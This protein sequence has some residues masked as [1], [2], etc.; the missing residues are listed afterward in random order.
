[1]SR[2]VRS[3]GVGLERHY[4]RLVVSI[5]ST[6]EPHPWHRG[7][8]DPLTAL[9]ERGARGGASRVGHDEQLGVA[10]RA[11]GQKKSIVESAQSDGG[12]SGG[13]QNGGAHGGSGRGL[14]R[15]HKWRAPLCRRGHAR[16][17][18]RDA[19]TRVHAERQAK[20][21]LSIAK[22]DERV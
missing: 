16:A 15:A 10:A 18:W 21:S 14:V 9:V 8:A 17:V 19:S 2:N 4:R 1:M 20:A 12:S 3:G 6:G 5:A 7:R 22:A 13:K 11:G